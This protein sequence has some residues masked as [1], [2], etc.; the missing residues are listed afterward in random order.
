VD[1]QG[2]VRGYYDGT[3]AAAMDR[4]V[5]DASGLAGRAPMG[6]PPS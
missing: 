6:A 5:E 3:D 2:Q 1:G 4:L